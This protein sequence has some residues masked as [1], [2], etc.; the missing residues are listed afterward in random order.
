LRI[1]LAIDGLVLNEKGGFPANDLITRMKSIRQAFETFD[2]P[3]GWSFD[4]ANTRYD[5]YEVDNH[6]A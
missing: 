1:E 2:P 6:S 4:S 5:Q 3:W